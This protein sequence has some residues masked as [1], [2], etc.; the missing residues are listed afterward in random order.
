MASL[1][2]ASEWSRGGWLEVSGD[3]VLLLVADIVMQLLKRTL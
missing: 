1:I 3:A 2:L